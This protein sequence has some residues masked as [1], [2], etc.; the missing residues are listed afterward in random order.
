M[1][2]TNLLKDSSIDRSSIVESKKNDRYANM[3]QQAFERFNSIRGIVGGASLL[4]QYL[5]S[6]IED[7]YPALLPLVTQ[8]SRFRNEYSPWMS[9]GSKYL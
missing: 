3:N 9:V 4:T 2:L 8:P 7:E 1:Q 5:I 6:S